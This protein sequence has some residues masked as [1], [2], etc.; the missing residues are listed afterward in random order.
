MKRNQEENLLYTKE[1]FNNYT[2][3]ELF[4]YLTDN[5]LL[6]PDE[7]F[8]DWRYFREYMQNVCEEFYEKHNN[9]VEL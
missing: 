3:E 2:V 5:L 8:K 9:Y 4:Y 6:P 7:E 1:N